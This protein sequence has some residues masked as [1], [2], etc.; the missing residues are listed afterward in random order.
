MISL[1]IYRLIHLAGIFFVLMGFGALI[2]NAVSGGGREAPWRKTAIITHGVGLFLVL[3][4]G[5]GMLAR[6]GIHW[7]WPGWIIAKFAVWILLGGLV[8]VPRRAPGASKALWWVI[9]LLA[10]IAAW[11]ARAKPF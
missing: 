9:L 3:L 4:G 2:L 8:A 10:V 1:D 6:L 5:F 11:I 7:P